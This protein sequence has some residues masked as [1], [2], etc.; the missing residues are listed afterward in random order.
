MSSGRW[1]AGVLVTAGVAV[2]WLHFNAPPGELTGEA[3]KLAAQSDLIAYYLPMTELVAARLSALELPLWNPHVCSGIPLFATLQSGVLYPGTWLALLLP[4]QEALSWR[5]L[6]ECWLA[7]LL[8]TWMFRSWGRSA[9][10]AATGGVLYVFACVVGQI[11]W[12]PAASTLALVPGVLLCAE[13]RM[14]ERPALWSCAL[15]GVVGLQLL[16]GF[17]QYVV[18]GFFVVLPVAALRALATATPG[19]HL[20][21]LATAVALGFGLAAVQLIPS[22][23]LARQ[24]LR[25]APATAADLHYLTIWNPYTAG[26]VLVSAFDPAPR[27]VA[28]HLGNSGGYL[29]TATLLLASIAVVFTWRS[30][31]TRLWLALGVVSLVLSNGMLGPTEALY[32]GFAELPVIGSFRTPERLRFVT[33]FAVIALAVLGFDSLRQVDPRRLRI[34][35][36]AASGVLLGAMIASGTGLAGWRVALALG[37]V[38]AVARPGIGDAGRRAAEVA[39]FAFVVL[40]LA[41]ATGRYGPLREIPI[42]LSNRFATA[43]RKTAL[44]EGLFE[45]Q[46]DALGLAR[47]ALPGYRPRMAT[48]PS[49]GG[50]RFACYEPL[51]P[52]GWPALEKVLTGRH[53]IGATLFD[54]DPVTHATFYDVAGVKRILGRD[55]LENPDALPRAYVTSSYRLASRSE[56]FDHLRDGDVD[57]RSGVLLEEDPGF[58][59]AAPAPIEEASIVRYEPERVTVEASASGPALLVLTDTHHPGWRATVDGKAAKILRANGLFRA[60]VLSGGLQEVVFEYVPRSV[61]WG[62]AISSASLLGILALGLALSR[63]GRQERRSRGEQG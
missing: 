62:A 7:G 4:P 47:I 48:A 61:W 19:R 56:A 55:V 22:F 41:L 58:E 25:G 26:D 27:L 24:S 51:V 50:Y 2:L 36:V 17:P 40:D 33:F 38:L 18:Y 59:A 9:V 46:R 63:G 54:L 42:E 3:R 16:A 28:F 32:R 29:G 49:N 39:L 57:F 43:D 14:G 12:P 35:A 34:A 60:V 21:A 45:E 5:M 6:F 13:K 31:G 8:A 23:E 52:S 20:L 37:L 10:A 53:P 11:L 44:P 30:A 15:A 1:T